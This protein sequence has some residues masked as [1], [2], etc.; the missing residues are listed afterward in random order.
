MRL[1]W[2]TKS[3]PVE[4]NVMTAA[5]TKSHESLSATEQ[6]EQAN[7]ALDVLGNRIKHIAGEVEIHLNGLRSLLIFL[8]TVEQAESDEVRSF[9]LQVN[10][11]SQFESPIP[12][13][14]TLDNP[15]IQEAL[16]G[17]IQT[18]RE[19]YEN[20]YE[21]VSNTTAEI[22]ASMEKW[23]EK[24]EQVEKETSRICEKVI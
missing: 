14:L 13:N 24:V 23:E 11:P 21:L 1:W 10:D 4:G 16:R 19:V 6:I 20:Y 12:M 7:I 5:V 8:S 3:T 9:Q 15:L 2:S 18:A 17:S 22:M